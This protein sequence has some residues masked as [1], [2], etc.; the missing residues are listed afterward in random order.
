[1]Q[2]YKPLYPDL[3]SAVSYHYD[4]FPPHTLDYKTLMPYV[5]KAT[6]ALARYDQI[7][8]SSSKCNT[9]GLSGR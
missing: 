8:P 6:D 4:K 5:V 9:Q 3:S 1:M 7:P 2:A